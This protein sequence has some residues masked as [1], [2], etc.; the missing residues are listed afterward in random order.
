MNFWKQKIPEFIYD[1]EYEKLVANKEGEI[2][3]FLNFVNWIGMI[4]A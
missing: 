2:R 4:N 3:K 1:V